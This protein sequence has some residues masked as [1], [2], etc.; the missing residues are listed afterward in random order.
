MKKII[1][2]IL[3]TLALAS[4][5]LNEMPKGQIPTPNAIIDAATANSFTK[6]LY[7]D[8]RAF[9]AGSYIYNTELMADCFNATRFWGRR[10]VS[11]HTWNWVA[12]DSFFESY[13]FYGLASAQDGNFLIDQI[14][15]LDTKDYSEADKKSLN[16]N[17]A[18]AYFIRAYGTFQLITKFC[19][20][21]NPATAASDLGVSLVEKYN[22]APSDISS[23]PNRSSLE[24]SYTFVNESLK[25]AAEYASTIEG[26]PG[27]TDIT[28]D[29]V[30]A[31]QARVAL[32]QKDYST[33]AKLAASLV[34]GGTYPLINYPTEVGKMWKMWIN[35]SGEECIMQLYA[36]WNP[37]SLPSSNS[38]NYVNDNLS[39]GALHYTP[40]YIP[41]MTA[42]AAAGLTSS[43]PSD[44]RSAVCFGGPGMKS[45]A[46]PYVLEY[47]NTAPVQMYLFD[48]FCGNPE[49]NGKSA[50]TTDLYASNHVNK[51]K[52]FRIAEQYLI[53]AE[54][55]AE[56]GDE[57]SANKYLN[58][59]RSK[60]IAGYA[61]QTLTGVALKEAVK[62]ERLIELMGEGFRWDDLK[63][64]GEG[65]KRVKNMDDI[66]DITYNSEGGQELSIAADDYRWLWPIPQS[67]IDANP[68]I[69]EQQNPGYTK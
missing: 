29:V 58:A 15:K 67:E 68:Q 4:C 38:Y 27:S 20:P 25:K 41:S 39:G 37:T 59:L 10:G 7:I 43:N 62:D 18:M 23:Y 34:D 66:Q 22:Y 63:R 24:A 44:Y 50:T 21:Y 61:D 19:K 36:S 3:A 33:A 55:Y 35:D 65:L 30:T 31:F 1:Y 47:A 17:M 40:D 48:K 11:Y 32:F 9:T 64:W 54:A 53:A 14:N 57:T 69:K 12:T 26:E 8:V 16:E 60:R 28:K 51:I 56:A 49:L 6:A 42:L 5:S 46:K 52:P 45:L 2:S 13:W